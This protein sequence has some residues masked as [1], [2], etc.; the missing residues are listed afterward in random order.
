MK[1]DNIWYYRNSTENPTPTDPA[2]I[3]FSLDSSGDKDIDAPDFIEIIDNRIYFY[4][5]IVRDNVLKLNKELKTQSSNLITRAIIEERDPS[6][7]HLHVSSFGGDLFSSFSAMD[8]VLNCKVPVYT[9]VD[10]CA[11]SGATFITIAGKRRYI[12]E[13]AYMLIHQLSSMSWGKY[14]EL[15]DEAENVKKLMDRM[16]S[17]YKKYTKLPEDKLKDLLD[18]DLYLDAEQCIEYGLADEIC[19]D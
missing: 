12:Q 5:E 6:A 14:K 17:I 13:N 16:I 18:H 9:Y 7:I 11:M 1:R 8:S 2:K 3:V 15:M 19:K 4:S 10:G